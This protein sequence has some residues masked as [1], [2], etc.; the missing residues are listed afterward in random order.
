M[1]IKKQ[2]IVSLATVM[3]LALPLTLNA[4]QRVIEESLVYDDPTVARPGKWIF[5]ASLDYL[6]TNTNREQTN[7]SGSATGY[8]RVNSSQVGGSAF[9]GYGNFSLLVNY[10]PSKTTISNTSGV[11]T[12]ETAW[13]GEANIR[14]LIMDLKTK[15]FVP[16]VLGGYMRYMSSGISTGSWTGWQKGLIEGPGIGVGG[17]IPISQKYGFRT[18]VKQYYANTTNTNS[19]TAYNTTDKNQFW[20]ITATG[21]YNITDNVNLQIGAQNNFIQNI[22]YSSQTGFYAKLGYTWH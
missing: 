17:I 16:Y 9:A 1:K 20:I 22:P 13:L 19:N 6:N 21:Y 3:I 7:S 15:Y 5:G 12:A 2:P 11:K 18:D 10:A 14:W 4:Q 8:E